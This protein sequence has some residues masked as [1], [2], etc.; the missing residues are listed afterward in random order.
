MARP[1]ET[2]HGSATFGTFEDLGLAII[3]LGVEYPAFQLTPTDLR[4]LVKRHYRDSPAMSKVMTINDYTGIDMRSSIGTIDDPFVNRK[5]APAIAELSKIFMKEG[6]ALAVTAAQ[7]ALTEARIDVSDITHIVSTTCTNSSNPGFDHYVC[8]KLGVSHTVEKVLLHGVG[9]AGGLAALRTAANIAMGSS[10]RRR[11]AR[12]LVMA[13]EICT[14]LVR[15]EMDSIDKFQETRIG[16]SLFSDCASALVLSNGIGAECVEEP[17]YELLGWGHKI[18]PDTD[19]DLG[20]NVDPLGWKVVLSPRVPK[21]AETAVDPIFRNLLS[22]IPGLPPTYNTPESFDWAMHPGGA[23]ILSGVEKAMGITP[24]HMRAS[25]DIYIN[26]GNSSAATIISVMDRL[27][28]KDMDACAPDGKVKDYVVG[29][30]FGPG[31]AVEM[32]MLKRNLSHRGKS[33]PTG[34]ITLPETESEESRSDGEV[35]LS[36]SEVLNGVDLD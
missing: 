18:I 24:E 6:V 2:G 13:L 17:I 10:F 9:C 19:R 33:L 1:E 28:H 34:V 35:E 29:C 31:M 16:V 11:P 7:K 30:A 27:R 20:F 4:T 12:V 3:G 5:K 36:L 22:S 32:C 14:F 26:H 8:K 23:T 15:S 25:Y 21:I